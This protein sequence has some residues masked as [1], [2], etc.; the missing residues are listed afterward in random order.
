MNKKGRLIWAF[1]NPVIISIIVFWIFMSPINRNSFT[2]GNIFLFIALVIGI[3]IWENIKNWSDLTK[4][5]F[6]RFFG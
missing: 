6:V 4:K 3:Y 1:L 2:R 5:L